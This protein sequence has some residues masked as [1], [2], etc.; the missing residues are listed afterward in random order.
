M[1]TLFDFKKRKPFTL[2]SL[3]A[4]VVATSLALSP[5]ATFAEESTEA[6]KGDSK[7]VIV[8]SRIKR[9]DFD[10]ASP[11][12]TIDAESLKQTGYTNIEDALNELPQL[13]IG[14]NLAN[15]GTAGT[16]TGTSFA[17][18][19]SMGSG[20]TLV[21][22][23]GKR[24]VPSSLSQTSVDLSNIPVALVDKV[25][26]FTG[27]ASAVYGSDAIAGVINVTLKTD[28]QGF[29][30]SLGGT[31][32]EHGGAETQSMSMTMGGDFGGGK[33]NISGGLN[34][35]NSERLLQTERDF[36]TGDGYISTVPNPA[37]TNSYDGI[38][39]VLIIKN[40][41]ISQYPETGGV[42][43]WNPTLGVV[44]TYYMN[45][46]G[47]LV[48][49]DLPQY[50]GVREGGPGFVFGDY[51]FQLRSKQE[52]L[53][54][55]IQLNYEIDE[56]MAFYSSLQIASTSS[57]GDFQPNFLPNPVTVRRDNPFNTASV[58]AYMDDRG[59]TELSPATGQFIFRTTSDL[60]TR[61]Q[62]NERTTYT[63]IFGLNGYVGNWDWDVS[64]QHGESKSSTV[65]GVGFAYTERL[66]AAYDVVQGA[67]GPECRTMVEA[68]CLPLRV[69][70]QNTDQA[71]I[72]WVTAV[73][74]QS[75][76]NTQSIFSGYITGEIFELPGGGADIVF[77]AEYREDTILF[78]PDPAER[79]G[80]VLLA[81]ENN[82]IPES[83]LDVSE[84]FTEINLPIL[85]MLEVGA[86]YR[87]SDYS[88]V[89]NVDTWSATVDFSPIDD[90]AFRMTGSTSIRAPS[91]HDLFN[92][93]NTFFNS[94][95]DPCDVNFVNGGP[96][97][98]VRA[99]NCAAEVGAGYAD[100]LI[101]TTRATLSGG[102]SELEPE[103]ADTFTAGFVITPT[104]IPELN[105]SIDWWK[106][107]LTN[108]I[109]TKLVSQILSDCY[110][111]PGLDN[112]ACGA[113]VRR[114]SDDAIIKIDGGQVNIGKVDLEGYDIGVEYKFDA[115]NWFDD[116]PGRF[117]F[118]LISTK[119]EENTIDDDGSIVM[120]AGDYDNPEWSGTFTLEYDS[121][122]WG[123]NLNTIFRG[124][125][126]ADPDL[127][128]VDDDGN[129]INYDEVYPNGNGE[130]DAL[131]RFDLNG[132]YSL[133]SSTTLSFGI[134]NLADEEPPR[135]TG[136]FTGRN[137]TVDTIGRTYVMNITMD[138]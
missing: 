77:G 9:E 121:D 34:Y 13:G 56:S 38:P 131:Y 125:S 65:G 101:G 40:R 3:T 110:D 55:F 72:D 39:N 64:V 47:E 57:D 63:A 107:E 12:I 68:G 70:G 35:S 41:T 76:L 45:A 129:P 37:N 67:D 105:V 86:A 59:I 108:K 83:N 106:I 81:G 73:T 78:N 93:G 4:S 14:T 66:Y 18:L 90:I 23:N 120:Q 19:R 130:V 85:E 75:Q 111:T 114:G 27:G 128:T 25:E 62:F 100:P 99:A 53:N 137:G 51:L 44:E 118:R 115:S 42:S 50:N 132:Y 22:V 89:G 46:N 113:I 20:R 58:N 11:I 91:V 134:R 31:I 2:F 122:S 136:F 54:S 10:S 82:P 116:L 102:N 92:P 26:I 117:G 6:D 7:I 98:A 109:D 5:G 24:M 123:V 28:Y 61:Q 87:S 138:L 79:E 33:G 74:M 84:I 103:E 71:A 95:N 52:V 124:A 104:A 8:G 1:P 88:T 30:V 60:G 119:L 127:N 80:R 69:L 135:V 112:D 133:S 21:L 17:N 29:R 43:Y 16:E 96:N 94:I 97:P 126:K 32:P 49:N 15:N 36:T 48:F